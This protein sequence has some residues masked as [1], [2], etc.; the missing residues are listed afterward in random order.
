MRGLSDFR[1]GLES[2]IGRPTDSRPF[3]CEGSPLACQV[4]IVGTNPATRMDEVDWWD[5]WS[6]DYGFNK[7]AWS[8]E[9]AKVRNR[10]S[11]TRQRIGWVLEEA[12]PIR[13]LETNVDPTEAQR[14]PPSMDGTV[15]DYLLA[16]VA[17]L[18]VIA[19]GDKAIKH[20]QARRREWDL[21]CVPHFASRRG[22]WSEAKAKRLGAAV[23]S[24]LCPL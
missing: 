15:L 23:R 22:R 2:Q 11:P 24:L 6:D 16:R 7:S 21:W 1:L 18:L 10:V 5:F 19:H 12:Q 9:Y 8:D 3:V 13:C 4:L 14:P 17:P 20:L